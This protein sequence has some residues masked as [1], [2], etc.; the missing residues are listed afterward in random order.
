[1]LQVSEVHKVFQVL[2]VSQ[3]HEAQPVQRVNAVPTARTVRR[4]QLVSQLWAMT[5]HE[6]TTVSQ[7][8]LH[9]FPQPLS[10]RA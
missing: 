4:V 6:V 1:V 9:S 2:P 5:V 8:L 3:V 10:A 7:L